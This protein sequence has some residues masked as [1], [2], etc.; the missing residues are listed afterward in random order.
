M[1]PAFGLDASFSRIDWDA[2][3]ST[4]YSRPQVYVQCLWTGG[5]AHYRHLLEVA[6]DNL[7][8]ARER[9]LVT[10]GYIN[11]SPW[12]TPETCFERAREAARGEWEHLS[13]LAVDVEIQ[14]VSLDAVRRL[15]ELCAQRRPTCIYTARWFWVGRLGDPQDGWLRDYPLWA[16]QY[17]GRADLAVEGFGPAGWPVVGKQ[18]Q[19]TT[20]VAGAQFDLNVFD[21]DWW[22]GDVDMPDPRLDEMVTYKV[23]GPNWEAVVKQAPLIEFLRDLAQGFA[24][25]SKDES[26]DA[27]IRSLAE[28]Q[29]P[30]VSLSRQELIDLLVTAL[31]KLKEEGGS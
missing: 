1:T 17:D 9:G 22:G 14:G 29:K 15:C 8:G 16:A 20:V 10:A 12:Y 19:G 26:Q 2:V 25:T 23:I 24:W 6:E 11:V 30:P 7:R 13:R 18:F 21:L 31:E 28:A 5:Y 27:I 4:L 3:L